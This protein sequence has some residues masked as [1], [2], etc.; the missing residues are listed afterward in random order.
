MEEVTFLFQ[1]SEELPYEVNFQK[2]D[3]NLSATCT[4]KAGKNGKHCKHKTYIMQGLTKKIVSNNSNEVAKVVHMVKETD[5]APSFKNL[6]YLEKE[7]N[8][9]KTLYSKAKKDLALI[10]KNK[11]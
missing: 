5:A 3:D 1:G 6:M 10:M 9:I 4:C 11:V 8:S 7:F 2:S